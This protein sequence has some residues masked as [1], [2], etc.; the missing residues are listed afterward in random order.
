VNEPDI[1]GSI[2]P[3]NAELEVAPS[4]LSK[5]TAPA[6]AGELKAIR[7]KTVAIPA[8]APNPN[9]IGVPR[10]TKQNNFSLFG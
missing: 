10:T 8:V 3:A 6:Q 1:T 9:R 2:P 5:M 7:E 4:R